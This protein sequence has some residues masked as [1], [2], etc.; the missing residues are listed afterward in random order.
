MEA[1]AVLRGDKVPAQLR[2]A[3][4][5]ARLL[6][7]RLVGAFRGSRGLD[8]INRVD[9]RLLGLHHVGEGRVL[10]DAYPPDHLVNIGVAGA[11]CGCRIEQRTA[12]V[13]R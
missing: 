2:G 10:D 13:M 12:H 6:D 5:R 9:D 4:Q 1:H 3:V 7:Q 11:A 8:G